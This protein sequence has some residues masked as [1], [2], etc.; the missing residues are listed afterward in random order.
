MWV[1]GHLACFAPTALAFAWCVRDYRRE[2]PNGRNPV[3]IVIVG[4]SLGW[5]KKNVLVFLAGAIP[6]F[7]FL[8][9][10]CE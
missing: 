10:F 5:N 1:L 6:S 4:I 2:H 8:I 9:V 7:I 3:S